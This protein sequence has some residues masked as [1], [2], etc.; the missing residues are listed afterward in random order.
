MDHPFCSWI[1]LAEDG[2]TSEPCGR[3]ATHFLLSA[4]GHR[5]YTCSDH[6]AHAKAQAEVGAVIHDVPN[7]GAGAPHDVPTI[8]D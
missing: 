6:L 1:G 8:V 4:D 3:P 5:S 2:E 7:P